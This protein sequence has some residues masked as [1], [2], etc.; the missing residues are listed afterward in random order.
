MPNALMRMLTTAPL[1]RRGTLRFRG[2]LEEAVADA[3]WVQE[4]VPER[5]EVKRASLARSTPLRPPPR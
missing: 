4:S 3:E 1:P 5:L 2:E